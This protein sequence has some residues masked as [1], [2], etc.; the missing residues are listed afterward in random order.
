MNETTCSRCGTPCRVAPSDDS[1]NT[2]L[3]KRS[4]TPDGVC[5]SCAITAFI[6]GVPTLMAGIEKNGVN[7]LRLPMI[8]EQFT[9]LL[10]A[11]QSDAS[12]DEVDWDRVVENWDL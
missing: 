3:L 7:I 11:G 10:D 12:P 8:Q 9:G 6:K 5:A 2:R 1:P 4:S